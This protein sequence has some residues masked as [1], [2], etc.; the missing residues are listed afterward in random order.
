MK[1]LKFNSELVPL[2]LNG[3]KTVTWRLYDDKNLTAGDKLEFINSENNSKFAEAEII[4][5]KEKPIS[6]IDQNDRQGHE[7]VGEGDQLIEHYKKLYRRD[8]SPNESIKIIKF[9]LN[10]KRD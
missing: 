8:V 2:I 1:R 5:V 4:S 6:Q 3:T 7:E 9:K 10:E